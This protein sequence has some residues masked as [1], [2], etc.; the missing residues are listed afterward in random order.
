[1]AG[2]LVQQ[3]CGGSWV[4]VMYQYPSV[5]GGSAAMAKGAS[6][7]CCVVDV[8]DVAV[9]FGF[10]WM[11]RLFLCFCLVLLCLCAYVDDH[12]DGT[13]WLTD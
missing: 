8:D 13:D 5:V 6:R 11:I 9:G 2:W 10:G 12:D 7:G 1:M 4:H 3:D